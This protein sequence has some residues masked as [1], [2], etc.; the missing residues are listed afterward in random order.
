MRKFVF[1][2]ESV[3][4]QRVQTEKRRQREL[5]DLQARL[6]VLTTTLRAAEG[7]IRDTTRIVRANRVGPL[8]TKLLAE[9]ARFTSAVRQKT[10]RLSSEI[11]ALRP[12]LAQAHD[13]LVEAA[14]QRKVLEKLRETQ[15]LQWVAA[16]QKKESRALDEVGVAL[17]RF[18]GADI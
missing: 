9:G 16:Q 18:M 5:A 14:K 10:A 3:L 12:Q 7:Q 4:R 15:K 11:E 1:K 17:G 8:D 6:T 13:A 2:L